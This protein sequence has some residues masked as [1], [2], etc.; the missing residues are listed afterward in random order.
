MAIDPLQAFKW[1]DINIAHRAA[2]K[3]TNAGDKYFTRVEEY[4]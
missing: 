3:N 1:D 2:N 4:L